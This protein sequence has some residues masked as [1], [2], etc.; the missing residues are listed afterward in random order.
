MNW[1][2]MLCAW[3]LGALTCAAEVRLPHV[4]SD[5]AVLQRE[6]PLRVWGWSLPGEEVSVSFHDQTVKATADDS[7]EWE[8]FLKP[9]KAGGPYAM[10][11]SGTSTSKPVVVNDLL[12]GDVWVASGQSNMEFP[13]RGWPGAPMKDSAKEIASASRPQIRL[14]HLKRA[15]TAS[16]L[17]DTAAMWQECTPETAQSFSAVAYLFG[18]ELN[19]QEH[20]PIGLIDTTWGGTPVSSWI[21]TDGI[22]AGN[23]T[24]TLA[25]EATVVQAQSHADAAIANLNAQNALLKAAGKPQLKMPRVGGD[26]QGAWLV[27]SLYNGMIAPLTRYGIKG[28]I[29]YQGESDEIA[30]RA[31][32]YFR[33]FPALITDW[34]H[35]WG[36]GD[37]PF[38]YVQISSYMR[39]QEMWGAVRDAQRRTLSLRGTG[40]A[41]SLDVGEFNQIHP[42]D[43]Q[44]VGHRLALLARSDVYG[45]N[46]ESHSPEFLRA[47]PEGSAMRVWLAHGEALSHRTVGDQKDV[48]VAAADGNFAA[49]DVKIEMI[50]GQATLLVSSPKVTHPVFVRYAWGGAVGEYFYNKAGLPLGTF[51]T[52]PLQ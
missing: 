11:V 43:K 12:V 1:K 46:V 10:K 8:L 15:A 3:M 23:L 24:S 27:S 34:R 44:S 22:A 49:A 48:E 21:S 17:A 51:T 39:H 28:V 37:F 32:N 36:E 5:H 52:A 14:M 2:W 50:N 7:G 9:E 20:V 19:D 16:E 29:W 31:R 42:A 35:Q 33:A 25:D 38:L 30:P 18:R 41:V 40:Q 26:H 45:E 4:F 6:M 47:T 13:L